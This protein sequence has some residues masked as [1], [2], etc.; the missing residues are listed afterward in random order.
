MKVMSIISGWGGRVRGLFADN[1]GPW[2]GRP[3]GD[4]SSEPPG[5]GGSGP[6]GEPPRRRRRT[7][8]TP[9]SNVTSLEDLLRRSRMRFGGGGPAGPF[10]RSLIMWGVIGFIAVW[11]VFTS[12]HSISPGQ[13]GVVTR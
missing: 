7:V 2:G 1:K 3:E 13:R 10:D 12:M 8:I 4:D 6:W 9:P 5:D 11:L